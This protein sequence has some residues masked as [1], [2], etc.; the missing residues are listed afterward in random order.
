MTGVQTCA[1]PICRIE[2][3][4]DSLSIED[5]ESRIQAYEKKY[6]MTF[7]RY[8]RNFSCDSAD[9]DEM[10]D[11]M[12]WKYLLKERADRIRLATNRR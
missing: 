8:M 1:L 2:I 10:T 11:Y 3:C 7:S 6:K 9:P 5:I 12:D 4:Y